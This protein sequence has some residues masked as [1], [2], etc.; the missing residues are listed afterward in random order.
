MFGLLKFLGGYKRLFFF[1]STHMFI[2]KEATTEHT[3]THNKTATRKHGTEYVKH[4]ETGLLV[5]E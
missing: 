5:D 3:H 2:D 4:R 1:A